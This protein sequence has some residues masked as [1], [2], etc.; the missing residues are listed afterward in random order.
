[1]RD[2]LREDECAVNH[3]RHESD[4]AEL[5]RRVERT[6]NGDGIVREHQSHDDD[7]R[8]CELRRARTFQREHLFPVPQAANQQAQSDYP[9]QDDHYRGEYRVAGQ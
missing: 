5:P 8:Q 7:G 3:D 4:Q 9:I 2:G 1:M 6:G